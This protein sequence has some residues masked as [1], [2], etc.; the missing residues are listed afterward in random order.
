[1]AQPK[2]VTWLNKDL[3]ELF[4]VAL[5]LQDAFGADTAQRFVFK[6]FNRAEFVAH[7]PEI[8]RKSKRFST[9]RFV[10]LGKH[11]RMYYRIEGSNLYVTYLFD[12]RQSPEKNTYR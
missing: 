10:L 12:T 1:M 4:D 9:L 2:T 6:A 3:I 11:H 8:G 5:Y 7:Q